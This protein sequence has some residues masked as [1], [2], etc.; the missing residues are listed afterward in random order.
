MSN[1]KF[2][3]IGLGGIGF[4]YDA[5]HPKRLTHYSCIKEINEFELV[6]G[7]DNCGT[8][9][10]RFQEATRI[11][12]IE[13]NELHLLTSQSI[14]AVTICTPT[15]THFEIIETVLNFITPKIILIEKPFGNN[16]YNAFQIKQLC[17]V[18]KIL[19]RVN[20]N[21]SYYNFNKEIRNYFLSVNYFKG[22][23][24]Y[25]NGFFNNASHFIDLL[26]EW[27]GDPREIQIIQNNGE[28]ELKEG[29]YDLDLLF[30]YSKGEVLLSS[31]KEKY[32]SFY[33]LNIQADLFNIISSNNMEHIELFEPLEDFDYPGFKRLSDNPKK[34]FYFNKGL[35]ELYNKTLSDLKNL[36]NDV[37]KDN[38]QSLRTLKI[39]NKVQHEIEK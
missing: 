31:W 12:T 23:L 33:T 8:K 7:V 36:P 5:N 9:R 21:R 34:R 19:L 6:Y 20:Y 37:S 10:S 18:K 15:N 24:W 1:F 17:D 26:C 13:I 25:S 30:K 28:S 4:E 2:I 22:N 38:N 32:Y 35:I 16:L 39:L 11:K 3:L 29:D 27:I 14:D